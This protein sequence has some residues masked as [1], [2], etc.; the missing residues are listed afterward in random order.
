MYGKPL[1]S[2]EDANSFDAI[3]TDPPYGYLKHKLDKAF[4]EAR[5]FRNWQRTLKA[6]KLIAVF[7]FGDAFH[8]WNIM[9]DDLKFTFKE[10]LVWEKTQV[11]NP[12]SSMARTVEFITIR[13]K[14]KATIN[15][16]LV[17]FFD[18]CVA[19]DRLD[20]LEEHYN[21]LRSALNNN[22]EIDITRL[23]PDG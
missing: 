1:P 15:K 13:S 17:D 7:G 3:I 22:Q 5:I 2:V 14:G 21:R 19:N 8:R 9:L 4:D 23:R 10:T 6:N 16:S 12:F 18:Y 11:N 20:S